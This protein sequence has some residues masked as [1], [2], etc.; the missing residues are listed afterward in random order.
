ML[1]RFSLRCSSIVNC[2]YNVLPV[3]FWCSQ[4]R[5]RCVSLFAV[6][7]LFIDG[8]VFVHAA[9]HRNVVRKNYYCEIKQVSIAFVVSFVIEI[10][11]N[12]EFLCMCIALHK[13]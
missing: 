1:A 8:C 13:F 5:A 10:V 12:L 9:P 6:V 11:A 4:V 3:R 2:R 7:Y